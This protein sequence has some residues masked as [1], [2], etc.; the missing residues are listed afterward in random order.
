M[1]NNC[2][3]AFPPWR[4]LRLRVGGSRAVPLALQRQ[5]PNHEWIEER[6]MPAQS[7]GCNMCVSKTAV[8]LFYSQNSMVLF[9]GSAT[10]HMN[11]CVL[12]TPAPFFLRCPAVAAAP[13][14][15][16][17]PQMIKVVLATSKNDSWNNY[18]N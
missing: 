11:P 1:A 5:G 2:T 3:S 9:W 7:S 8:P 6:V 10:C 4:A 17:G 13:A 12:E 18:Q 15:N 16:F 14:G